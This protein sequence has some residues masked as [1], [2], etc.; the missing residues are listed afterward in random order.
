MKI[1]ICGSDI[2]LRCKVSVFLEN[3]GIE[4]F[5]LNPEG[6]KK[7]FKKGDLQR[8]NVE[9][10][11]GV[12]FLPKLDLVNYRKIL[13]EVEEFW[14]LAHILVHLY[15]PPKFFITAS[16][17]FI[18]GDKNYNEITETT[19]ASDDLL[20]LALL[21]LENSTVVLVNRGIRV[22]IL[23]NALLI[24]NQ[25]P[26]SRLLLPAKLKLDCR[27]KKGDENYL[28][29]IAL[30]DFLRVIELAATSNMEGVFNVSSPE[31]IKVNSMLQLLKNRSFGV[32][33]PEFVLKKMIGNQ[34]FVH[35]SRSLK[36]VPKLLIETGF[37][38]SYKS[39]ESL[40]EHV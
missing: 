25:K 5:F 19:G 18:Y 24:S 26:Y 33:T 29:W 39:L 14:L 40:L 38:F 11:D 37:E 8:E 6:I 15:K 7:S 27:V 20:A 4:L 36:I 31:E 1:L 13:S 2:E 28:S 17:T 9:G 12:I 23:R 3:K 16:S 22:V 30:D 34:I 32:S 21:D 10:F 35:F